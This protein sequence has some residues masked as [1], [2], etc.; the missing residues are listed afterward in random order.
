[1]PS[2][3]P[4][5]SS[6]IVFISP[7]CKGVTK[8]WFKPDYW[9]AQQKLLKTATGRGTVWFVDSTLGPLVLRQYRRGG[10]VAKVNRFHFMTQPLSATRPYQEL[11]LLEFMHAKG[12]HVPQP[13]AGMV[14]RKGLFYQA[15]LLTKQIPNAEDLFNVLQHTALN[16]ADWQNIGAT[17]KQLHAHNVYHSDLNCHNIM[18]DDQ[19]KVWLIDFDKCYRDPEQRHWQTH[20]LERLKRS[21]DKESSRQSTFHFS[22]ANWQQLLAGYH[23]D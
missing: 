22:E 12:L 3:H 16:A 13:V 9:Q 18:L 10:L 4:T 8:D 1:M 19:Q 5:A 2:I 6:D 15:W 11:E 20:N 23:A 17:I 7:N 14:R 21:F